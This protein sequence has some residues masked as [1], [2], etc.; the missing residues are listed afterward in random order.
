MA[1]DDI[2]KKTKAFQEYRQK[3]GADKFDAFAAKYSAEV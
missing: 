1:G 2:D 3:T